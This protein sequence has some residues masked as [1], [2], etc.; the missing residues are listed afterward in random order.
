MINFFYALA[1]ALFYAA[2]IVPLS[3]R[4]DQ[5]LY[6]IE[7]RIANWSAVPS[8]YFEGWEVS[9]RAAATAHTTAAVCNAY[10]C[11]SL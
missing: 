11:M 2:F 9:F 7:Q 10:T 1:A 6:D 4:D 3:C 8:T 5:L